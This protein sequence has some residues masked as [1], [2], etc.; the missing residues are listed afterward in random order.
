MLKYSFFKSNKFYFCKSLKEKKLLAKQSKIIELALSKNVKIKVDELYDLTIK[1]IKF[2]K[3][4]YGIPV[5]CTISAF[6]YYAYTKNFYPT[7]SKELTDA[8]NTCLNGLYLPLLFMVIF[9]F[10]FSPGRPLVSSTKN[11]LNQKKWR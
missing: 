9:I 6:L 2:N 4:L 10:D 7:N 8:L 5:F 1:N 11:Q 3:Y